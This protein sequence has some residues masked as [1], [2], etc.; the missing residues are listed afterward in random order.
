MRLLLDSLLAVM[1]L[2]VLGA[3]GLHFHRAWQREARVEAVQAAVERMEQ[4][5]T[6]HR[7]LNDVERVTDQQRT[8]HRYPPRLKRQW[9][10]DVP[11]NVLV[12]ADQP[13]LDVAPKADRQRHP[14]DPVITSERQ[15]GF[16]YNPSHGVIRARVPRRLTD[17]KM[18]ELYNTLN[19]TSLS[20]LPGRRGPEPV[21][22]ERKP[23]PLSR[24]AA[25]QAEKQKDTTSD[26]DDDEAQ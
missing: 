2:A 10:D 7:A 3:V 12:A 17:A 16:W 21:G 24:V 8:S 5:A 6:Y 26:K 4:R 1:V 9:F 25:K 15:A 11:R 20:H 18:L 14:P 19:G 13:W 23:L 22:D